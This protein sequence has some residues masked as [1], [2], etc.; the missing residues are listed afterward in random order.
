MIFQFINDIN[1][2]ELRKVARIERKE[3]NGIGVS[4]AYSSDEGY[5][6]TLLD[7]NG[8]HPVERYYSRE[9]TEKGHIKWVK[10]ANNKKNKNVVKLGG[11][12]GLVKNKKITLVRL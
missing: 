7:K 5:E 6:T 10:F 1:N 8:V 3:N 4:T 9:E 12:K 11:F 2:Y